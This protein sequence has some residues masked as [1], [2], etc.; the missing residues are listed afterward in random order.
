VVSV[1]AYFFSM[2]P[3]TPLEEPEARKLAG[4][5][6]IA[7]PNTNEME[8]AGLMNFGIVDTLPV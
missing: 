3:T 2:A 8:S 1:T 7:Q 4:A 5:R 6:R